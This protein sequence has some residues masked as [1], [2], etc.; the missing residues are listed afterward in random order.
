M[1]INSF[2]LTDKEDKIQIEKTNDHLDE[3]LKRIREISFNLMPT[4]LLRKGIVPAVREFVDYLNSNTGITFSL[5]ATKNIQLSEQKSVNLYRIIQ[6]VVHNTIKHAHATKF[7]LELKTH[8]DIVVLSMADNG[9]GFDKDNQSGNIGFGLK[10]LLRRTEIMNGK[11]F[12][13]STPGKGTS[14]GFEIPL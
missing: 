11:M 8:K 6:E 5:K 13:D 9:I 14:Y 1:K 10:S 12:I 4:S 7:A 3:V 2:D